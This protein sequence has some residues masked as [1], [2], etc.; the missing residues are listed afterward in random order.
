MVSA[1]AFHSSTLFASP[2]TSHP[3]PMRSSIPVMELRHGRT[4]VPAMVG[5]MVLRE[6]LRAKVVVV[7][8][9]ASAATMP[10]IAIDLVSF[11]PLI[12]FMGHPSSFCASAIRA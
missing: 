5:L 11:R 8:L 1:A 6:A 9:P 7:L 4:H 2:S 12:R 3:Q 10:G